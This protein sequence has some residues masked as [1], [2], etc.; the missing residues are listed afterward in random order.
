M[1]TVQILYFSDVLCIWAYIAQFRVN[2]VKATHAGEVHVE[3][4]FCSVFGDTRR[5]VATAWKDKGGYDG[6]AAHIQHVARSFPEVRIS[7]DLWT[8][9]RPA[10]S[11]GAHVF[12]KAVRLAADE[13]AADAATAAL[14]RAFFEDGRDI[15]TWDVQADIARDIGVD[16]DRIERAIHTGEAYAALSSDYQ[17]AAE[18]GINGSPTFVL[19]EGRQKL[20]GNVGYKIIEANVQELLRDRLP[21]QASW[22]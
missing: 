17:D 18:M 5:K 15:A 2:E 22:C 10:S 4:R 21:D 19:N 3:G 11:T 9:V 7:S 12:L 13:A 1:K 14:R 16:I 20:Y 6:F 8:R